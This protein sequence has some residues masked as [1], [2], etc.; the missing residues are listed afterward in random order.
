LAGIA[1]KHRSAFDP[2][3]MFD[4]ET[5]ID[6]LRKLLANV[7]AIAPLILVLDDVQWGDRQSGDALRE[8]LDHPDA[9]RVLLVLIADTPNA[10]QC[11]TISALLDIYPNSTS[12]S[13]EL[14]CPISRAFRTLV[15]VEPLPAQETM[16]L[17]K[18]LFS[19]A[20]SD[21]Q[22]ESLARECEG[23]PGYLHELFRHSGSS[24]P[25]A[26]MLALNTIFPRQ[27]EPPASID[28][29]LQRLTDARISRLSPTARMVLQVVL[30]APSSLSLEQAHSLVSSA[31]LPPE[32]IGELQRSQ[33][34]AFSTY[35][36]TAPLALMHAK[37][38][39]AIRSS[40]SRAHELT[41]AS[42]R[43]A[44]P[45][46]DPLGEASQR[47]ERGDPRGALSVLLEA[48]QAT[49]SILDVDHAGSL[50]RRALAEASAIQRPRSGAVNG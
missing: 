33:L 29:L 11:D 28:M 10:D 27:S 49:P 37:M 45:H 15:T 32:L 4:S 42:L 7:A 34:I 12:Q 22:V 23:N 21:S 24:L 50:F 48:A 6:P 43:V 3:D 26:D 36:A 31:P 25:P 5:F 47:L 17:A 38:E 40:L 2:D 41:P 18:R 1:P 20:L 35:R 44:I 14:P 8:L 19:A 16:T 13:A 39:G 30:D 46:Q 9:P